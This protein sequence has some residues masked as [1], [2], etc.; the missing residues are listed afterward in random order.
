MIQPEEHTAAAAAD[1]GRQRASRAD[2]ERV[3]GMLEAAFAAGLLTKAEFDLG[4]NRTLASQTYAD[5]AAAAAGLQAPSSR[6]RPRPESAAAWGVCGLIVTAFLTII[7]VPSGTTKGVVAV[8]AVAV[9]GVFCL[10]AGIMM[11]ASGRGWLR[12]IPPPWPPR[13]GTAQRRWPRPPAAAP[14]AVRET[15]LAG[16]RRT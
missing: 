9:Y 7:I 14:R 2:R 13:S 8:T 10:L 15:G 1:R 4:V 12:L 11:L 16:T 3:I 5:L 6:A